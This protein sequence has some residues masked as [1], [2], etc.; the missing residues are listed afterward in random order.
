[1]SPHR[2][3]GYCL[4][5]CYQVFQIQQVLGPETFLDHLE[6]ESNCTPT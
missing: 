2:A 5:L 1:M 6:A 3:R 4:A